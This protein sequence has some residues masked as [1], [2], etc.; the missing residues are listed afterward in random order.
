M[1]IKTIC[2][3]CG[4]TVRYTDTEEQIARTNYV[5]RLLCASTLLYILYIVVCPRKDTV[6]HF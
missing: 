2:E 5:S 3:V 1:T 4:K 6:L